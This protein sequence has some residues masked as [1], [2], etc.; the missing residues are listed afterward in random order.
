MPEAIDAPAVL[1]VVPDRDDRVAPWNGYKLLAQWEAASV[2][3]NPI[4]LAGE[5]NAGHRGAAAIE[6][7]IARQT[8][9]WTFLF[10]HL[11]M[12]CQ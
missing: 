7:V 11:G 1:L 10:W 4:L 12:S 5:L 8:A 3:G 9:I 6:S 2:S